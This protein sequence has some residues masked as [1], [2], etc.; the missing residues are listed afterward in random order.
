[1]MKTL[2]KGAEAPGKEVTMLV[3][4]VKTTAELKGG[5]SMPKT[6]AFRGVFG[7]ILLYLSEIQKS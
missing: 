7:H 6:L 2:V 5:V 4:W 3:L 1:M